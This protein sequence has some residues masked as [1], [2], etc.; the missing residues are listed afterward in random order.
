MC[1]KDDGGHFETL[2]MTEWRFS[3]IN[4]N[5]GQ[6]LHINGDLSEELTAM[7]FIVVGITVRFKARTNIC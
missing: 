7:S 4:V 1:F 6:F 5:G 3:F 2:K